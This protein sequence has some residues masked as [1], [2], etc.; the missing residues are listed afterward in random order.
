MA[1]SPNVIKSSLVFRG[2]LIVNTLL[3]L[4]RLVV[5]LVHKSKGIKKWVSNG[6]G[7]LKVGTLSCLL[8]I[9]AAHRRMEGY[10][11]YNSAKAFHHHLKINPSTM[12]PHLRTIL[13][14]NMYPLPSVNNIHP[15]PTQS[16]PSHLISHTTRADC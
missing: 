13:P 11:F 7:F 4:N 12:L 14:Q 8:P 16:R 10:S 2:Y 6:V 3:T 5:E 15:N 9:T 1:S